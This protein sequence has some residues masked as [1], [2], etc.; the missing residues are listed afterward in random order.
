MTVAGVLL[1]GGSS[2]RMGR[3]KATL[4]VRGETLAA[5]GAR[6]LAAVCAPV[7][8]VGRGVTALPA[9][10]EEP[11]GAGPL[12]ALRAGAA[13]VG[14]LP[15]VVLACDLPNICEGI[16]RMLAEW[17]GTGTVVPVV[18]GR[19]QYACARYG[20][21]DTS[22]SALRDLVD[23]RAQLIDETTWRAYGPPDSFDDVDT[24]DD[25]RRLRQP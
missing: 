6:V 15:V 17:P 10:R 19:A 2:T 13:A 3:D 8:E 4:V 11:P 1:T 20:V 12:A 14:S 7:V 25:L 21:I 18:D 24:P 16:V 23:E 5:R 22:A 9:V